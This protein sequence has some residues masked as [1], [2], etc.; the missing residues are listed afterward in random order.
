MENIKE[1]YEGIKKKYKLPEMEELQRT[2]G[3]G[4]I[5]EE[6]I[7]AEIIK[8]ID[9]KVELFV[10][11]IYRLMQPDTF[12]SDMHESGAF[13]E[14]EKKSMFDLYKKLM[15]VHDNA[16]ILEIDQDEKAEAAFIRDMHMKWKDLRK[17]MVSIVTKM[18]DSWKKDVDLKEDIGYLG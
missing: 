14:A 11:T 2:F 6:P 12:I 3:I 1:L 4:K 18:R 8:K 15:M 17:E 7:L 10:K 16:L 9:D 5:E 13:T